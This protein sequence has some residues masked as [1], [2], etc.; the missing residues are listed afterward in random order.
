MKLASEINKF[1]ENAKKDGLSK[2]EVMDVL[3]LTATKESTEKSKGR[4]VCMKLHTLFI[5][6]SKDGSI[7]KPSSA[8][9]V[10]EKRTVL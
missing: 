7:T 8:E 5:L 2:D 3:G 10:L 4:W 9:S 1:L 6:R